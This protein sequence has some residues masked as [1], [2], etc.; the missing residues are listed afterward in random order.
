MR[1]LLRVSRERERERERVREKR[2]RERWFVK[3]VLLK[4]RIEEL[5]NLGTKK[6]KS[7]LMYILKK[8]SS[9]FLQCMTSL[10][11]IYYYLLFSFIFF[12]IEITAIA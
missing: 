3:N 2:E 8:S 4:G 10:L 11:Q 5:S 9:I 6:Q 1:N 7:S 12:S